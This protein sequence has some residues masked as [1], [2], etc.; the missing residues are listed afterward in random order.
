MMRYY[1][2]DGLI[3]GALE[4]D[5]IVLGGA[6]ARHHTVDAICA[7]LGTVVLAV[8]LLRLLAKTHPRTEGTSNG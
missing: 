6:T 5:C 8:L 7:F 1:I 3:V 4:L 2:A